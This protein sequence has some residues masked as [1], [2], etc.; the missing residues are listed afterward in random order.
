V[1]S[2]MMSNYI[3]SE[4]NAK[5]VGSRY[6]LVPSREPIYQGPRGRQQYLSMWIEE[7]IGSM[8]KRRDMSCCT[9]TLTKPTHCHGCAAKYSH[10]FFR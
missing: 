3:T 9:P 4:V 10:L 1:D 5:D 6:A 8:T 7:Y 2:A